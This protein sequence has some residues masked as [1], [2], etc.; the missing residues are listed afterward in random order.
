M[1]VIAGLVP[2]SPLRRHDVFPKGDGRVEPGHDKD[3]QS[4]ARST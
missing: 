2:V 3:D 4:F 1:L